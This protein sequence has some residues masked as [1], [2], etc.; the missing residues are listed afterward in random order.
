MQVY[1]IPPPPNDLA[2][3]FSPRRQKCPGMACSG[4]GQPLATAG[5]SHIFIHFLQ[6]E[7]DHL[8][9]N[10][11]KRNDDDGGGDDD[12]DDAGFSQHWGF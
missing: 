1:Y 12:D 6:K 5:A 10:Y 8:Q 7:Q 2:H 3:S 9:K 11:R 4:N